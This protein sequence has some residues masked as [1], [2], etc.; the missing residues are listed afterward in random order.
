MQNDKIHG[1][2]K[3]KR[4]ESYSRQQLVVAPL[5]RARRV[6][7]VANKSSTKQRPRSKSEVV[8]ILR[9]KL[10]ERKADDEKHPL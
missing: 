1:N 10:K 6:I 8:L 5:K 2:F 4:Y 9:S 3:S 7:V